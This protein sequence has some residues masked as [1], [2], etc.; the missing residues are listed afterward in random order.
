MNISVFEDHMVSVA[1]ARLCH[2]N[3]K[4]AIVNTEMNECGY[5]A[6][7]VYKANKTRH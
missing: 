7:K 3:M 2:Y 6:I 1:T 5:V 4:E